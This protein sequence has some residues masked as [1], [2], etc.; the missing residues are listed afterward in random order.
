MRIIKIAAFILLFFLLIF[1]NKNS[2]IQNKDY[3]NNTT[4]DK[5][6]FLDSISL[7]PSGI[8]YFIDNKEISERDFYKK[9]L[10]GEMDE[11]IVGVAHVVGRKAILI[12]G[13]RYRHGISI[14]KTINNENNSN[15]NNK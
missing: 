14:W 8:I 5:L 12:F 7:N 13:E 3:G 10:D 15:E 6:N 9:A 11:N 1:C 4:N 2:G